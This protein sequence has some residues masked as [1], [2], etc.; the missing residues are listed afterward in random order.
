MSILCYCPLTKG[1]SFPLFF[2]GERIG[3]EVNSSEIPSQ[4]WQSRSGCD[5]LAL[6]SFW[7]WHVG[8]R[9]LLQAREANRKLWLGW[10]YLN[11]SWRTWPRTGDWGLRYDVEQTNTHLLHH[12][13]YGHCFFRNGHERQSRALSSFHT[14]PRLLPMCPAASPSSSCRAGVGSGPAL[15]SVLGGNGS[16]GRTC[17]GWVPVW[18]SVIGWTIRKSFVFSGLKLGLGP[19]LKPVRP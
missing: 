12:Q 4:A 3:V 17:S 6:D 10:M 16:L 15:D 1:F 9:H 2:L 11:G 8:T 19:A 13:T 18:P 7:A 5:V 14:L